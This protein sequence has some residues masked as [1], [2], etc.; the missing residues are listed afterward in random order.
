M[1]AFIMT[2]T[3]RETSLI[4]PQ[5]NMQLTGN[6]VTAGAE[7]PD[8]DRWLDTSHVTISGKENESGVHLLKKRV[9]I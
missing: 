1:P 3:H 2:H 8:L 4:D 9:L 6:R 7:S 5:K